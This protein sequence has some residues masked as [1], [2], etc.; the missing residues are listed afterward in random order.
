M[1]CLFGENLSVRLAQKNKKKDTHPK[2]IN[3]PFFFN[4]SKKKKKK[5]KKAKEKKENNIKHPMKTVTR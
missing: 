3:L 2:K 4:I 5:K 1:W